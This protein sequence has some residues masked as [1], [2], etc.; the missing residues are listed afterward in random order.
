MKFNTRTFR[1]SLLALILVTATVGYAQD[2][3]SEKIKTDIRTRESGFCSSNNW[4]GDDKVSANELREMTVSASG[5]ITVD[6]GQNGGIGVKGEDRGDILVRAC[7]QAWGSTDAVAKANVASVRINTNGIIKADATD[8]KNVSVSYQILIP[9][10]TNLKLTAHNGG[11]S[12]SGVDGSAEFETT[13]GGVSLNNVS[14]SVKGKTTNGGVNVA[15]SGASWQGSGL[16]V[17]TTNGGVRILMPENYAAHVEAGTVNGGFS[18]DIPSLNVEA[19]DENG[20]RKAS[21]RIST[22]LNGGGAPIRIVT[23]NGGVRIS[24]QDEKQ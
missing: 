10:S 1:F 17:T 14:G 13:N 23:T 24:A 8:D 6:G 11:I 3:K 12:I 19:R 5:S 2:I 18:S 9:R 22:D 21:A 7:V 4:S 15:L 20:R 16:D